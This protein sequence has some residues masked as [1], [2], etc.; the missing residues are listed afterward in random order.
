MEL[1]TYPD[2]DLMMMDLAHRLAVELKNDLLLHPWASFAWP[3][4]TR[5]G[6]L[7]DS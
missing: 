4:G 6:P 1:I 2:A 7:F 5:L 3:G